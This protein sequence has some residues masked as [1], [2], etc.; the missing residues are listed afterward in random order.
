MKRAFFVVF[1]ILLSGC[2]LFGEEDL[3]N[4]TQ[5]EAMTTFLKGVYDGDEDKV[6]ALSSFD[7]D[8]QEDI[9]EQAE[10][11]NLAEP[12]TC[13]FNEKNE[14]HYSAACEVSDEKYIPMDFSLEK[15]EDAFFIKDYSMNTAL[16]FVFTQED[17]E[18]TEEYI[19][20]IETMIG[21]DL[22]ELDDDQMEEMRLQAIEAGDAVI[23]LLNGD[24]DKMVPFIDTNVFTA[25]GN[26]QFSNDEE[27]VDG[28]ES[29][30][31]TI[32]DGVETTMK[33]VQFGSHYDEVEMSEL[34]SEEDYD[35]MY[36]KLFRPM[37]ESHIV[38]IQYER[39][40]G[41]DI[42]FAGNFYIENEELMLG[43]F[44]FQKGLFLKDIA[45]DMEPADESDTVEVAEAEEL[46]ETNCAA[47]HGSD[48]EGESGPE[49]VDASDNFSEEELRNIIL[50]GMDK[51][52]PAD[53]E[54]KEAEKISRWLLNETE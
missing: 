44:G 12:D 8:K 30:V 27:L 17:S 35:E 11:E 53:L 34:D 49:L 32:P 10:D 3:N 52:P 47:C 43:A 21:S 20:K 33:E 1:I 45:Y 16:D 6:D 24:A 18:L 28:L 51:M 42:Y 26:E 23:D 31:Q 48:M 7:S 29:S 40:D 14:F 13:H 4:D 19:H 15:K 39:N 54:D 46:Y 50:E 5:E 38:E 41:D 22:Y 25:E 36:E 2:S 9:L 37:E